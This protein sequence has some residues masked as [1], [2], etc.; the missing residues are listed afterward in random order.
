[1]DRPHEFVGL[2]CLCYE[3]LTGV[4]P[5]MGVRGVVDNAKKF[6]TVPDLVS[7]T[8]NDVSSRLEAALRRAL[9]CDPDKRFHSAGAFAAAL[10]RR[11]EP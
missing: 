11:S 2:A 9:E 8:R 7:A 5:F 4:P 3:M 6:T 10:D 1:M